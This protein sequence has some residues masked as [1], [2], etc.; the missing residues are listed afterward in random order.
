MAL[1]D[2]VRGLLGLEAKTAEP[3]PISAA[4]LIYGSTIETQPEI[5]PHQAWA[6]YKHVASLAKVV[7]LI[8]DQVAQIKPLVEVNGE[9]VDTHEALRI[10]ARPGYN[11]SR[12]ALIKE[13]AIQMLVTG[14][15]CPV[16]LGNTR[17]KPSAI[18]I[19]HTR[20]VISQEGSDGWPDVYS[21]NEP[22]RSFT[23][24]RQGN[25]RPRYISGPL[26]EMVPIYDVSGDTKGLGL[27]RLS[28]VATDVDMKLKGLLH[29]K[30]LLERGARLS[31]VYNIEASLNEDQSSAMEAQFREKVAGY[32]NAGGILLTSG[33]KGSFVPLSLTPRDLDWGMLIKATDDAIADRYGVPQAIFSIEAQTYDNLSTA[34]LAFYDIAVIPAW[35]IIYEPLAR[36]L[37]DRLGEEVVFT[38]DPKDI[39]VLADQALRKTA[40]LKAA[41]LISINEGRKFVGMEP[42]D[43]GD[44]ILAPVGLVPVAGEGIDALE[45]AR[46]DAERAAAEARGAAAQKAPARKIVG[47]RTPATSLRVSR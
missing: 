41:G 25:D 9:A 31:G 28:A 27:S 32:R 4:S 30:N 42:I 36:M 23:F 24:V 35:T 2:R 15:A 45:A 14:T 12:R 13:L 3:A 19:I 8:A 16:V 17:S 44:D 10:L 43:G 39:R 47:P 5:A 18:D 6:L 20:H 38:Y 29:N 11:R 22:R 34:W 1:V 33:G 26:A 7:D 21:A 40:A 46:Q 37:S